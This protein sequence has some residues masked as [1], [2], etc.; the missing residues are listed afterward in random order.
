[1]SDNPLC[2]LNDPKWRQCCCNCGFHLPDYYHCSVPM[3]PGLKNFIRTAKN[4]DCICGV[5]KG[6]ICKDPLSELDGRVRYHS[7]WPEH[8]VGCELYKPKNESKVEG[9]LDGRDQTS[10][11]GSSGGCL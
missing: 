2:G 8:S 3:D 1:M 9:H 7:D 11:Y 6:R 5:L 4:V 10:T